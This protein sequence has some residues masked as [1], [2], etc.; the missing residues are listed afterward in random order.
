[1]STMSRAVLRDESVKSG[2]SGTSARCGW[3]LEG[4]TVPWVRG[5]SC[6]GSA[7][8]DS[9]TSRE[10]MLAGPCTLP[11]PMSGIQG[12]TKPIRQEIKRQDCNDD[13]GTRRKNH[14]RRQLQVSS[15]R[16]DH[17]TPAGRRRL[18]P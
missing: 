5:V 1:M 12:N 15:S 11:P 3:L 10:K 13:G 6:P 18:Y 17:I 2:K 14:P 4:S 9:L 7:S 8:I 16:V